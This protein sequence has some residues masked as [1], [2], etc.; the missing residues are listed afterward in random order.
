MCAMSGPVY[1]CYGW[2][3]I[4]MLWVALY[5]YAMGSPVYVCYVWPCIWVLLVALYMYAMDYAVYVYRAIYITHIQ[6]H[7]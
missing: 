6:G 5:K 2:P 4:C 3:C 1:V 7:L